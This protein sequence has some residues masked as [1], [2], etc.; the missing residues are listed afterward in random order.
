MSFKHVFKVF[1][2]YQ[3]MAAAIAG[4]I[5][6]SSYSVFDPLWVFL[7][8]FVTAIL[9]SAIHWYTGRHNRVDDIAEGDL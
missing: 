7:A 1:I 6:Y 4:W 8:A 9:A 3:A 5:Y 2:L